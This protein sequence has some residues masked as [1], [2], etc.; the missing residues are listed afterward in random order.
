MLDKIPAKFCHLF[1]NSLYTSKLPES[2]TGSVVSLLP[3]EGDKTH[4]GNWRPISQTILFAKILEKIVHKQTIAYFLENKDLSDY[5]YGFLPGKSTQ[6]AVF[7][8]IRHMY[9]SINQ[10]KVMGIVFLDV[11]K[12]FN[13][14]DHEILF[15]IMENVSV[16]NRVIKWFRT[17]LACTQIVKYGNT[18]SNSSPV[19]AGIAQGTVLG[20]LLFIFYVNDCINALSKCKIT[21]FADDC[22]LYYSGNNWNNVYDIVQKD[23]RDFEDWTRRNMLKLNSKKSQAMILGSRNKL[24]KILNPKPFELQNQDLKYVKKYNYLGIMLDA[25]LS[26]VPLCKTIEKTIINKVFMLRTIGHYL[27]HKAAVQIYKQLIL[28]IIDYA[29]FILIACN[30][31]K[32]GCFQTIQNDA[33]RFCSR[34]KRIDGISLTELHKNSNL[35]SLEQRRCIQLLTLMYKMSKEESNRKVYIRNTRE[36]DKFEF[37]Q[38]T[39][40]GTKYQYSPFYKGCNLWQ[41]LTREI[42]FSESITLFKQHVKTMYNT[43]ERNF[44]V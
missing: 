32:K 15:K 14:I 22:V 16:S 28:P 1:A 12:A 23:L 27:T 25:E 18:L 40:I 4:P 39:K 7:N 5:Q 17:Y 44:Y 2:W 43:F 36:Q 19:T 41:K 3:K 10:N 38:D 26:L 6:E 8:T 20:P 33:L 9:S 21:M 35:S 31:N 29:G 13:C 11:A 30:K 24:S 34:N 42:Q 37:K